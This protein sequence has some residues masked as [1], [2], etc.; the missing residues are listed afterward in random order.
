MAGLFQLV[1]L[2]FDSVVV[3]LSIL[4]WGCLLEKRTDGANGPMALTVVFI[5]YV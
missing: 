5:L 1:D 2:C 3:G 4:P